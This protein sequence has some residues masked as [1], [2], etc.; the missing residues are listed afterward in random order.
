MPSVSTADSPTSTGK[1]A[2]DLISEKLSVFKQRAKESSELP[3]IDEE[4]A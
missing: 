3:A 4:K 2:Q 1:S